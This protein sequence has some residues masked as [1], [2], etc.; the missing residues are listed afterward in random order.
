MCVMYVCGK[1]YFITEDGTEAED[2]FLS[3]RLLSLLESSRG[4]IRICLPQ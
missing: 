4:I 3:L 2:R 1:R